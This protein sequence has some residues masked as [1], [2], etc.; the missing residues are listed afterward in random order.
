MLHP[1]FV[2]AILLIVEMRCLEAVQALLEKLRRKKTHPGFR[3]QQVD[4]AF[5]LVFGMKSG[6]TRIQRYRVALLHSDIG[7]AMVLHVE[8][9]LGID[10]A[11]A[12]T[13]LA[14]TAR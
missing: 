5:T 2:R 9:A 3:T 4:P 7:T 1:V 8:R 13:T 6:P 14:A 12:P 11:L 10:F